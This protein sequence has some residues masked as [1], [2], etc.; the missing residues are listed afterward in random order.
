MEGNNEPIVNRLYCYLILNPSIIISD[1][2]FRLPLNLLVIGGLI[3]F[4]YS[5]I[6][7]YRNKNGLVER[8]PYKYI[9]H[10]QYLGIMIM[11][12]ALTLSC[13][14]TTPIFLNNAIINHAV[15]VGIWIAEVIAYII[16]AKIEEIH[17]KSKFGE[18]YM[19]YLH[20][21]PFLIPFLKLKR[22]KTM[23][24]D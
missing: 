5:L 20:S 24:T 19:N 18:S 2:M 4:I 12:F 15:I 16:L 13:F 9:R 1:F 10:P 7:L 22:S 17:L 8:G 3:L 21:V 6:F 14:Y 23:E 11:T